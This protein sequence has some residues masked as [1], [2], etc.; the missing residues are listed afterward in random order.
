MSMLNVLRNRVRSSIRRAL[1]GNEAAH[2][3]EI[4]RAAMRLRFTMP[5]GHWGNAET[6]NSGLPRCNK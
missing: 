1:R 5:W 3:R 2:T 4:E 6:A